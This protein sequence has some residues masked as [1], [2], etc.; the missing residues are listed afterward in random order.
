MTRYQ[1]AKLVQWAGTLRTRKKMQKAVYL[2]QCAGCPL[3]ADYRL[4]FFGPYSSEVAQRCDEMA[5][6]GLIAEECAA[7]AMGRSYSY[8]LSAEAARLLVQLEATPQGEEWARSLA[9]FEQLGQKLL[10]ADVR[11]LEVAATLAY[12][13]QEGKDW[14]AAVDETCKFKGLKPDD[15]NLK[16]AETLARSILP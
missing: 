8:R 15:A 2:L 3:D 6:A 10:Q 1:L 14:S 5:Q 4:H 12:F 13:H 7:H 11:D 9:P 16:R